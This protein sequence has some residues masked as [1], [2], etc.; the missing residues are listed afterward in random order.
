LNDYVDRW[1]TSD[2]SIKLAPDYDVNDTF[3]RING[4]NTQ[5]VTASGQPIIAVEG[6]NN[7]LWE[8]WAFGTFMEQLQWN[9]PI[10][11]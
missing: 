5:N 4:G 6:D 7:T 11:L 3:Y 2:F 8:Y 9:Y 1:H 10:K